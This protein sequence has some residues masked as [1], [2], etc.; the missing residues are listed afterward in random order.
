M[1]RRALL[2]CLLSTACSVGTA[3]HFPASI[4]PC[5][6]GPANEVRPL[7]SD[8]LASSFLICVPKEVKAHYHTAHT[9]HVVVLEGEGEMLLG[10]SLFTIRKGDTIAIPRG[11]AHA[12]RTTSV[13]PLRVISIQSPRFDGS[14]RV[15]VER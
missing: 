14:D 1:N 11:T 7:H 5:G 9:E 3:Q 8:S 6:T 13:D 10:D 15:P 12:A 4:A 2:I